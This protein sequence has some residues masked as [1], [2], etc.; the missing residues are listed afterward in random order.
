MLIKDRMTR[1]PICVT[2]ETNILDA[3]DLMKRHRIR[4]LPVK[5]GT[6]LVGIITELDLLKLSPSPASSLSIWELKYL[7]AKMAVKEGMARDVITV[8]PEDTIE[9]AAL[10]MRD[11]KIGGLPVMAGNELVGIITETDIFDAFVDMLG[12]RRGGTRISLHVEDK[13]GAMAALSDVIRDLGFNII[14]AVAFTPQEKKAQVVFRL[15]G[16]KLD[17]L[18]EQLKKV[19]AEVLHVETNH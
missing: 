11:N 10:L 3:L 16:N 13:P 12:I 14:S 9:K 15:E 7:V 4:R 17:G 19:G 5:E 2:P 6:K 1:N 8:G 18:L